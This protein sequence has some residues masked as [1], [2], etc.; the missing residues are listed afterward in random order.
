[1]AYL[2]ARGGYSSLLE[3]TEYIQHRER[4]PEQINQLPPPK[5]WEQ[6][7]RSMVALRWT[8]L[9]SGCGRDFLILGMGVVDSISE[10]LKAS[11]QNPGSM[12]HTR[13]AGILGYSPSSGKLRQ[14]G[15]L[16]LHF[17]LIYGEKKV[18]LEIVVSPIFP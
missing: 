18:N 3:L 4:R 7:S 6:M 1:M 5:C 2:D 17:P 10:L 9:A 13:D 16:P 8:V 15:V 12:L 14:L 11:E